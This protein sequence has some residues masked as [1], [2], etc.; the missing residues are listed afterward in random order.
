[1]ANQQICIFLLSQTE[2]FT[3]LENKEQSE[4]NTE[5]SESMDARLQKQQQQPMGHDQVSKGEVLGSGIPHE[6]TPNHFSANNVEP[7]EGKN[8]S[9]GDEVETKGKGVEERSK[10]INLGRFQ[11]LQN[12][13]G[14]VEDME[15]SEEDDESEDEINEQGAGKVDYG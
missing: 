9:W 7:K 6:G 2:C 8:T 13:E 10:N 12:L 5:Q 4:S 14:S 11:A 15:D 1:M 3:T